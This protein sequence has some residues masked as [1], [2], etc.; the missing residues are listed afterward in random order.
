[1]TTPLLVAHDLVKHFPVRKGLFGRTTQD[2]EASGLGLDLLE[3]ASDACWIRHI[4]LHRA[5]GSTER[6]QRLR[7]RL[8]LGIETAAEIDGGAIFDEFACN[9]EA[10]AL[11]VIGSRHE[12]DLVLKRGCHG[13]ALLRLS[14]FKQCL[15]L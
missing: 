4:E 12:G 9:A 3:G 14:L 8:H 7:E 2:V 6:C 5:C 13:G 11:R 15:N 1:M 10:E